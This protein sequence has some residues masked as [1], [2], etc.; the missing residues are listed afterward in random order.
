M[1]LARA[2]RVSTI[3]NS[4]SRDPNAFMAAGNSLDSVLTFAM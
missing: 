4:W 1:L 3:A 2:I